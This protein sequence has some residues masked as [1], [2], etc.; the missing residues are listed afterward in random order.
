M[1]QRRRQVVVPSGR[2]ALICC[3]H[4]APLGTAIAR[5]QP[6]V[7]SRRARGVR[8][9]F[10][11]RLSTR[12]A[13][14]QKR[15]Q[16]PRS[17]GFGTQLWRFESVP[18]RTQAPARHRLSLGAIH[19]RAVAVSNGILRRWF[20]ADTNGTALCRVSRLDEKRRTIGWYDKETVCLPNVTIVL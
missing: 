20:R 8:S 6:S 15:R 18:R 2:F 4:T 3:S 19:R 14:R 9:V 11:S 12:H 1:D 7:D 16:E 5:L 13:G 17:L 10:C